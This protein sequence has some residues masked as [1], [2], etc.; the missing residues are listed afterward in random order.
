MRLVSRTSTLLVAGLAVLVTMGGLVA[1][2]Q[3]PAAACSCLPSSSPSEAVATADIAFVGRLV[4]YGQGAPSG[5]PHQYDVPGSMLVTT[6]VK[7]VAVGERVPVVIVAGN[8]AACGTHVLRFT[9]PTGIMADVQPGEPLRLGLCGGWR[10]EEVAA[11]AVPPTTTAPP[12]TAPPPTPPP[13]PPP[14]SSPPAA[15]PVAS[16]PSFTG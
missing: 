2:D 9:Q 5:M 15:Q 14:A 8:G 13:T 4:E 3:R 10:A 11:L 12:T 1:L 16:Q 6:A 7:G